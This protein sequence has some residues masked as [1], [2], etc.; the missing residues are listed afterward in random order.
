MLIHFVLES[1]A[2]LIG[3]QIFRSVV[4]FRIPGRLAPLIVAAIAFIFCFPFPY[5]FLSAI[6]A[7][8]G[9]AV[10]IKVIDAEGIEPW[11]FPE[12]KIRKRPDPSHQATRRRGSGIRERVPK[13]IAPL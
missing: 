9:V 4:W 1:F 3:W 13:R 10:L 5:P 8:G 2:T 7:A 6:A 11:K 12:I